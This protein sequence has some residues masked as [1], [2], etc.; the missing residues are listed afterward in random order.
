MIF[1]LSGMTVLITGGYGYLGSAI[2]EGTSEFGAQLVVLG[3]SREKFDERFSGDDGGVDFIECDISDTGSIRAAYA[4]A[5]KAYGAIDVLINNGIYFRGNDPMKITDDDWQ[6]SIDGALNSVY[7]CIRE[8][9]PYFE[10]R[11]GGNI[12]NISSMYGMVSPDFR[13]YETAPGS[14]NPPHYGA[15]KA[16]LIQMTRYFATLLGPQGVRVNAISPGPF[17]SPAV[18]ER[19]QFMS[20]LNA[21]TALGRIGQ[22]QELVGAV[23][24]LASQASSYVTGHNLAVDGGWTAR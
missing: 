15:A 23:V 16:A 14:F 20:A 10:Q 5:A 2:A 17:P 1:D 21:R 7:R 18:Q 12:I 9:G 19:T 8:V 24:Y 6:Y 13:V 3:R 11:G 4:A 22:P